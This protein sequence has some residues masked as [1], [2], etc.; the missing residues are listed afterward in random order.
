MTRHSPSNQQ[1]AEEL[2]R[3]REALLND[4]ASRSLLAVLRQLLQS[5]TPNVYILRWIPEQGED[6]YDVLVDGTTVA[7][8]EIP[9]AGSGGQKICR[10]STVEQYIREQPSM[11]KLERRKLEV[12]MNLAAGNKL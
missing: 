11:T 4:E 7:Q 5:I 10:T 12:A 3:G 9:R 1:I 6:L 2:K 8:V